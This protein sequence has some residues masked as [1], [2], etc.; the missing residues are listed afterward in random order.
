MANVDTV[1]LVV[2]SVA[3]QSPKPSSYEKTSCF[4]TR[5]HQP[6]SKQTQRF[7][8]WIDKRLKIID[9]KQSY[10]A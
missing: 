7:I 10:S 4:I 5:H 3:I 9:E 2:L 6:L 8:G 1:S